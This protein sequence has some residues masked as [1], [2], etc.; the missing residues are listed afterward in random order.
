VLTFD[1]RVL[2]P[3]THDPSH[4]CG[5][6][7]HIC[8]QEPDTNISEVR[9]N[10]VSVRPCDTINA[11]EGTLEIEFLAHDPDGHLAHY[12]L[13][14][15]YGLNL[16]VNLLNRPGSVLTA[17]S[18]STQVGPTYGQALGQG[19]VAPSWSGGTYRLTVPVQE[20]FPEPCCY[21][22]E[23]CACKRTVVGD[24]DGCDHGYQHRNLTEYT[25]GVGNC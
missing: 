8:T 15:T 3:L 10:G 18:P 7:V 23:L 24:L 5:V 20:A 22:L 14:A 1:N 19:A 6:G 4:N 12:S 25:I 16:A 9:I 2:D 21:Q 11:K 13:Q 17:L